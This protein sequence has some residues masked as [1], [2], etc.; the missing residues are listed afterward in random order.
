LHIIISDFLV[1]K[2]VNVYEDFFLKWNIN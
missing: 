1:Q 2:C